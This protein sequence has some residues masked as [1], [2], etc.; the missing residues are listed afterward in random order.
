MGDEMFNTGILKRIATR[1]VGQKKILDQI[2]VKGK[3]DV[4]DD[5]FRKLD[6]TDNGKLVGQKGAGTPLIA[7]SEVEK[8]KDGI[9][10]QFIKKFIKESTDAQD[11]YLYLRANKARDFV[12]RDYKEFIENGGL[13][14]KGQAA[15]LK[16]F[17]DTLKFADGAITAPGV[18]SG[19]GT[20]FIQLKEAGAITQMGTVFLSGQGYIDPGTATAFVLAPAALSRL[21]TNPRLMKFLIDGTK[22]AQSRNFNQFSRFMGQFGSALVAEGLITEEN[23]S[24][25]QSNI[26]NN[27]ENIEKLIRGEIPDGDF[28]PEE[29]VN[30]AKADAIPFNLNEGTTQTTAEAPSPDI[31]LPNFSPANLPLGGGQ[32]SNLQLA[33]TLNLFNK[34]GIVSA[35]KV[36]T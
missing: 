3:N 25:V 22:G 15:Q 33:Q 16:E 23:N 26:K 10:G 35:K 32:Q 29:E 24:L 4:A 8:I 17:V 30:P 11:Q 19:R 36:N 2:L 31:P 18:K 1:D 27:Q 13:L 34:G 14:T 6:L 12:E 5:F 21:F 9:R 7:R 20:I 28:F